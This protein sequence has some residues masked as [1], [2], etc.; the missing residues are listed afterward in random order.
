M[1]VE[2]RMERT[3]TPPMVTVPSSTSQNRAARRR[4]VD[5]PAPGRSHQSGHSPL[6]RAQ[7]DACQDGAASIVGEGDV[8]QSDRGS[9]GLDLLT[10]LG[11]GQ[12]MRVENVP[13]SP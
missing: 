4:I 6:R 11:I 8:V 10:G 1:I 9:P 3:G 5:L 13:H 2:A 12:G 7:G